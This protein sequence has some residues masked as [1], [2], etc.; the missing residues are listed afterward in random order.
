VSEK[1]SIKNDRCKKLFHTIISMPVG[2]SRRQLLRHGS[3]R[4]YLISMAVLYKR[5]HLFIIK[6]RFKNVGVWPKRGG[7]GPAPPPHRSAADRQTDRD[8]HMSWE[9]P[10]YCRCER[11]QFVCQRWVWTSVEDHIQ[12]VTA[13]RTSSTHTHHTAWEHH[14]WTTHDVAAYAARAP[15]KPLKIG[16]MVFGNWP[17]SRLSCRWWRQ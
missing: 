13:T 4:S 17:D 16:R 2:C 3:K 11:R 9:K 1:L 7:C 14:S 10:W 6:S 15:H 8:Q 5:Q 12:L